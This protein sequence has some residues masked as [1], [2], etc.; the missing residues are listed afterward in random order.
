MSLVPEQ[1]P[2]ILD[3]LA[4]VYCDECKYI[5]GELIAQCRPCAQIDQAEQDFDHDRGN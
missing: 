4:T 2:E 1:W 3:D 5:D